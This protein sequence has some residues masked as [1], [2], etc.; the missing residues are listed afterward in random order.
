MHESDSRK[1]LQGWGHDRDGGGGAGEW[2]ASSR[3]H[4]AETWSSTIARYDR[5]VNAKT[6]LLRTS[7]VRRGTGER[8]DKRRC[9]MLARDA[10]ARLRGGTSRPPD[11]RPAGGRHRAARAGA[12]RGSRRESGKTT[13]LVARIAWLIDG[14]AAP[15]VDRGDH[16]QQAG[17]RRAGVSGWTPPWRRW[18]SRR[19]RS[20]CGRS[21]PSV[22]RSCAMPAWPWS[23]SWIAPRSSR[24]SGR[25]SPRPRSGDS[26]P[27]SP[28]SSST[29][30]Q[31]RPTVAADPDAGPIARAFVA[32]ERAIAERGGLDFDDLV[33]RALDAL[34]DDPVLLAR[35][36][37]RCAH[38]LVDEVQD[39]DRSQL[40][41]AL[42]LAAPAN[43]IFLVGDDDQSIYGWRLAD[44]RRVLA[45]GCG[46]SGPPARRPAGEPSL[47]GP[48]RRTGGPA[49]RAQPRTLREG[50]P[51]ATRCPGLADPGP[52]RHRRAGP[53]R[54]PAPLVAGRRRDACR[55]G[56]H[57]PGVAAGRPRGAGPR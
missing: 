31:R 55:P 36:R 17:R 25:T 50:R 22:G 54:T 37:D 49:D 40:R 2:P 13:T 5:P 10:D 16:I 33:R 26:T 18:A 46:A 34:D 41:L 32:Y 15:D 44:V 11:R 52:G 4:T 1:L 20:G 7:A 43:R 24:S 51:P 42:L 14:G 57:E 3:R 19:A 21:T 28:G 38:L 23:R 39:V 30:P 48:R 53:H 27:P 8:R 12:V 29:S 9:G 6:P 56:P 35:W 45:L 47:P